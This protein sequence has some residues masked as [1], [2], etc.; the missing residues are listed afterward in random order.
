[1]QLLCTNRFDHR[2]R[3]MA[4]FVTCTCVWLPAC[5]WASHYY[6]IWWCAVTTHAMGTQRTWL[7]QVLGTHEGTQRAEALLLLLL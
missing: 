7:I 4:T 6:C 5:V 1:M 3:P 2:G